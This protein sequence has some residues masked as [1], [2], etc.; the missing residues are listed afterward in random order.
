M[1]EAVVCGN[2]LLL[3]FVKGWWDQARDRNSKGV[4]VYKK[5]YDSLKACPLTFDHPSEAKQLTNIGDVL[6]KRLVEEMEKHCKDNGL[7]LPKRKRN[8]RKLNLEGDEEEGDQTASPSPKKKPRKTKPYVPALRSGGYGLMMALSKLGED[9]AGI[10]KGDLVKLA[11]PYCDASFTVP[12]NAGK[13]YTAWQSMGTLKDKDLVSEKGRPNKRYALTDEGWEVVGRMKKAN[14]PDAGN[15]NKFVSASKPAEAEAEEDDFADLAGNPIRVP[16]ADK[17]PSK[18]AE[19][20]DIIPQGS[21]VTNPSSLPRFDP[22]VLEPGS[23]TV[24]LV[25]DTREIFGKSERDYM[26]KNLK[27]KGVTPSMRS[28]NLGDVLWVA[29]MKDPGFL[30]RKG[31]EGDEIMLDYIVERKRVDDLV[32]SIKDGRFHEQKFRLKK[33]G[34]KNVIYL[35]EEVTHRFDAIALYAEAMQTAIAAAQIV[36]GFFV[37]RTMMMDDTIRYLVGMTKLLKQRYETRPLHVIPTPIVTANNYRPLLKHLEEKEP[38]TEYHVTYSAFA[39]L[40][41]KSE[42]LT[43]RDVYLKMLMCT[44]GL[45]GEKA[46]ELQKKWKTPN[47]LVLAYRQ[48]EAVHG[49]DDVVQNRKWAMVSNAMDN[50]VLRKKIQK[51]LSTKIAETWG[52]AST[53]MA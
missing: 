30:T 52:A 45:T 53:A 51:A 22:I 42:T 11:Q 44:R 8:K 21:V 27:A 15:M 12:Q 14:D 3:S 43:L 28:L 46:I 19:I 48:L 36:D 18:N 5:A 35:V 24:E 38:G 23:F 49:N 10:T 1:P 20:P 16:V 41:S 37:K 50:P 47:D 29:K 25:V 40:S 34:L 33:S 17:S 9:S 2:P 4:L 26:E 6:V 31:L 13:F 32:S 39:C 7:P